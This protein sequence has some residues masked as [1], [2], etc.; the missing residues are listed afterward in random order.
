MGTTP[1]I[2]KDADENKTFWRKPFIKNNKVNGKCFLKQKLNRMY[3][4][5]KG[6]AK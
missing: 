6:S 1:Q 5:E 4:N 3:C 2:G